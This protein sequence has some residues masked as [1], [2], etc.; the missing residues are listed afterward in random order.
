M[1]DFYGSVSFT[2]SINFSVS[3]LNEESAKEAIFEQLLGMT[4]DVEEGSTVKVDSIDWELIDQQRRGNVSESFI[5]D[6]DI[7]EE[8]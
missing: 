4:I 2:G 8:K 1:K 6:F 7:T 3:A 5:N